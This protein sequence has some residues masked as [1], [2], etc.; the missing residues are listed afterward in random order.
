MNK[1]RQAKWVA[2]SWIYLRRCGGI[3][4]RPSGETHSVI[5]VSVRVLLEVILILMHLCADR[6][7]R[8]GG[9]VCGDV[10]E[11]SMGQ[12]EIEKR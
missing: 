2:T 7:D 9:E 8:W 1:I 10:Q 3:S 6:L 11:Q 5:A 12:R 4:S